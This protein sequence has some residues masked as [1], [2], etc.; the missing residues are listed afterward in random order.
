MYMA[1]GMAGHANLT[2][3]KFRMLVFVFVTCDIIR[4]HVFFSYLFVVCA[5]LLG[6]WSAAAS[7]GEFLLGTGGVN[8]KKTHTKNGIPGCFA[9]VSGTGENLHNKQPYIGCA[10]WS[11]RHYAGIWLCKPEYTRSLPFSVRRDACC[12]AVVV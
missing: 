1:F 4:V 6:R 5:V 7:G 11:K 10:H 8:C 2:A 3:L 12:Y 9:P